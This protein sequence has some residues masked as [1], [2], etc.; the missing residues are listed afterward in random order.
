MQKS[1][2]KSIGNSAI[3]SC[4]GSGL[5]GGG[6][7]AYFLAQ[8]RDVVAWDP[9]PDGED[10]L[11][12]LIDDAWPHLSAMGLA[13]DAAKERLRYASTLESAVKDVGFIQESAPEVLDVKQ[14]LLAE[15]DA[16]A[17]TD[18][19]IASST[20]GFPVT[21]L[22]EKA[23]Y[24]ERIVAGHP[25]NPSYLIPLVEVAGGKQTSPEI[26]DNTVAFYEGLGKTVIR[27]NREVTGFVANRLQEAIWREASHMV[28]A[29]EATVE[30][31]DAAIVNGPGLR[32]AIYG[33]CMT[34]HLAV[35]NGGMEVLLERL[36][37]GR[38]DAYTRASMPDITDELK[39]KLIEGCKSEQGKRSTNDL[40][41][42]RDQKLVTI[43]KA[44]Q[45]N[46]R[47]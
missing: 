19:I 25:F 21:L 33:P 11:R 30:E 3:I 29:D 31:I 8:G 47:R 16:A 20:S 42:E 38:A 46:A 6:W 28:A 44:L 9:A 45:E 22:Q 34:Y 2:S 40:I 14:T 4:I 15:I 37:D 35:R 24:P 26:I 17:P 18:T 1:N 36:S 10:R 5:I 39:Q 43:L 7:A 13:P 41:I 23:T 12:K 27:L 32:W